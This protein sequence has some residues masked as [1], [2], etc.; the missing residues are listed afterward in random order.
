M[1][2]T[3]EIPVDRSS[4]EHACAILCQ[5]TDMPAILA[6]SFTSGSAE[7]FLL[8]AGVSFRQVALT[9]EW[10]K[11]SYGNFLGFYKESGK[12]IALVHREDAGYE[13]FDLPAKPKI[14]DKA[15]DEIL[16]SK[17]Y[18]I[19][20]GAGAKLD[21]FLKLIAFC[22]KG[23]GKEYKMIFLTG[24]LS[25]LVTFF[26]PFANKILIDNILPNFNLSLFVQ[27]LIGL[28]VATLSSTIFILLRALFTVRMNGI[29]QNNLQIVLWGKILQLPLSFFRLF[30]IGDLLQRTMIIEEIRRIFNDGTIR[31]VINGFFSLFFV[32]AMMYFSWVLTLLVTLVMLVSAA[33]TFLIALLRIQKLRKLL[34]INAKINGFLIQVVTGIAK[35]RVAEAINKAF[36]LWA[37]DFA[38][39]QKIQ[40]QAQTLQN[41]LTT[42]IETIKITIPLLIFA[43]IAYTL[44]ITGNIAL[45]LGSFLGFY[46]AM[47]LFLSAFFDMSSQLSLM[48][49]AIPFWERASVI[50]TTPQDNTEGR[51]PPRKLSGEIKVENL[52]FRYDASSPYIL[53]NINMEFPKGNWIG[54]SGP[55]GSGKTTLCKLLVGLEQAQQGRILFD[56]RDISGISFSGLREQMSVLLQ[57]S[58]AIFSGTIYDNLCCGS[59]R[60][61]EEVIEVLEKTQFIEDLTSLPMGL[62]TI[63]PSGGGILSGGQKQR[64]LLSRALLRK[65]KI[66]I[67]DEALNALDWPSQKQIFD[68]ISKLEITRIVISH[69]PRILDYAD[70]IYTLSR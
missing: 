44:N 48:T 8:K 46:T 64:L 1:V 22:A 47:N 21:T 67:L 33:I 16:S 61:S 50:I 36:T 35:L 2:N 25:T 31:I 9:G 29:L 54:L 69:S 34:A 56:G 28:V 6:P 12:P 57:T 17:A 70:L 14:V 13:L 63:L 30:P 49:H 51:P 52:F 32:A 39:A 42:W 58:S 11:D 55:S 43:G 19:Y 15:L 7:D 10:W 45:S 41:Y 65:P 59:S 24:L 27:V 3:E 66:L 26:F 40:F 37:T 60:T 5:Q 18:V 20:P 53:E 38:A 62:N 4:M 68:R 23:T